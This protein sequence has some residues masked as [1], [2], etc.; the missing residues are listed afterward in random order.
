MQNSNGKLSKN[1]AYLPPG[2]DHILHADRVAGITDGRSTPAHPPV[3]G[4]RK[5]KTTSADS[6][7]YTATAGTGAGGGD[8]SLT[9]TDMGHPAVVPKTL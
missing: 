6:R 3:P 8:A 5:L 4:Q 7:F 1:M 2:A 9:G